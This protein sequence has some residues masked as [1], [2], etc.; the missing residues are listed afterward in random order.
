MP[1]MDWFLELNSFSI[2]AHRYAYLDVP[3]A[4]V[5]CQAYDDFI[6]GRSDVYRQMLRKYIDDTKILSKIK[7][8]SLSHHVLCE[9]IELISRS[10]SLYKNGDNLLLAVIIP[11]LV[12]GLL[13]GVCIMYNEDI[14][15]L[16]KHG[17]ATKIEIIN[18]RHSNTIDNFIHSLDYFRYLFPMLRNHIAHGWIGN[19][20]NID[21]LAGHLILDLYAVCELVKNAN[22]PMNVL[23]NRIN[24]LAKKQIISF[25]YKDLIELLAQVKIEI[26]GSHYPAIYKLEYKR[27]KILGYFFSKTIANKIIQFSSG[28]ETKFNEMIRLLSELSRAAKH[29]SAKGYFDLANKIKKRLIKERHKQ[30]DIKAERRR[31]IREMFGAKDDEIDI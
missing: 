2:L 28:S 14:G 30:I 19:L 27:D 12:E 26:C 13:N 4:R 29:N 17:L 23:T 18:S 1:F 16:Y 7:K 20:K 25:E 22:Y 8:S 5:V 9:K 31:K 21:V 11:T 3:G 24:A 10:V 15:S 6:G